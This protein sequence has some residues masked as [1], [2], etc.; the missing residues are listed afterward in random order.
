M[1]YADDAL[2]VD[3]VRRSDSNALGDLYDRHAS[4]ALATA[5]RVVA[6]LQVAEDVVHDAFITVWQKAGTFD[7]RRGTLRSWLLTIV[8]NR[9]IDRLR[10]RRPSIDIETADTASLSHSSANPTWEAVLARTSAA[11]LR[12][13]LDGLPDAQRRAIEL[14]YFEGYTYREIALIT[15]VPRGTANGRLRLALAKLREVMDVSGVRRVT[16]AEDRAM[17]LAASPDP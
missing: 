11:E 9:A 16:S 3:R 2:L 7:A 4:S 5:M 14:A 10:A 12:S 17:P 8:R 15:G 13:V 6:D 1:N